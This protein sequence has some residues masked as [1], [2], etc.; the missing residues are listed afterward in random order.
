MIYSLGIMGT[1]KTAIMV[2]LVVESCRRK[3]LEAFTEQ[4]FSSI[5]YGLGLVGF[6]KHAKLLPLVEEAM[7]TKNLKRFKPQGLCNFL[8][9]LA[10][11][12]FKND[13][14]FLPMMYES[15]SR[16]KKGQMTPFQVA[17]FIQ[18]SGCLISS[19]HS[20][21]DMLVDCVSDSPIL[22][23]MTARSLANVACAFAKLKVHN[24]QAWTKVYQNIDCVIRAHH[25]NATEL[26]AICWAV[27][28]S[29]YF[30][31]KLLRLLLRSLMRTP[32]KPSE[33]FLKAITQALYACRQYSFADIEFLGFVRASVIQAEDLLSDW[34][35][36]DYAWTLCVL[37]TM[38]MEEFKLLCVK[39]Q[40][41]PSAE[42]P[43]MVKDTN[44]F[45][46]MVVSIDAYM[47]CRFSKAGDQLLPKLGFRETRYRQLK[48]AKKKQPPN[49]KPSQMRLEVHDMLVKL[50]YC[51][52]LDVLVEN[53][54]I[55]FRLNGDGGHLLV[56]ADQAAHF[57]DI[58]RAE[59]RLLG[60]LSFQ[61][62]LLGSLKHKVGIGLTSSSCIEAHGQ[63]LIIH[64]KTF[65]VLWEVMNTFLNM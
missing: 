33:T 20:I 64:S 28:Q 65:I 54:F 29:R 35:I 52:E 43:D 4:H 10:K 49:I 37:D 47:H 6:D 2:P 60:P 9:G 44:R 48:G 58:V 15:I 26:G 22:Q 30:D 55:D 34:D 3:R 41:A 17:S 46:E 51:C 59:E 62:N 27:A 45:S 40:R 31:P 16:S 11:M 5:V 63:N 13:K 23:E 38:T 21:V 7:Q 14:L 39:L 36:I 57:H 56:V 42:P 12:H 50:G 53:Y 24:S 25:S 32:Q 19:E 8:H 18:S 61:L 1:D